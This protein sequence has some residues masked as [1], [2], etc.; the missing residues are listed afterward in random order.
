METNQDNLYNPA[1]DDNQGVVQLMAQGEQATAEGADEQAPYMSPTEA[2]GA[3]QAPK[4]TDTPA[5]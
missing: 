4:N 2:E 1:D 3:E 5:E